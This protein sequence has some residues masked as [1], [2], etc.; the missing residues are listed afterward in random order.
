MKAHNAIG[1]AWILWASVASGTPCGITSIATVDEG[2]TLRVTMTFC[3]Y[4]DAAAS[5]DCPEGGALVDPNYLLTFGYKLYDQ[6]SGRLLYDPN[7]MVDPN[8]N[9]YDI[10][11]PADANLIVGRCSVSSSTFCTAAADCPAGQ[12]CDIENSQ[13]TQMHYLAGTWTWTAGEK[14]YQCNFST[15]NLQ[16]YP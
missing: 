1:L 7:V 3:D 6:S 15:R 2:A 5:T 11:I 9:P 10:V 14:P 12:A 4:S 16:S 13:F 8:A